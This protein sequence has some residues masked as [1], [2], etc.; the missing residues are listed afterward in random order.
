MSL[1]YW[2]IVKSTGVGGLA[3]IL[4]IPVL[5]LLGV[6]LFVAVKRPKV[7]VWIF[8]ISAVPLLFG[9]LAAAI[10]SQWLA[11]YVADGKS[12]TPQVMH[13]AKSFYWQVVAFGLFA[14]L[15]L[16]VLALV[17]MFRARR[18]AKVSGQPGST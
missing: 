11:Q 1:T 4:S 8:G 12:I 16:S 15:P 6:V 5:Y 2:D 10:G 3:L 18:S 7:H 14:S 9:I 13:A 17:A